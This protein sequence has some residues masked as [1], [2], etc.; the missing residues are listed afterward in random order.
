MFQKLTR[1]GFLQQVGL[2]GTGLILASCV[3]PTAQQAASSGGA[4]A[5]SKYKVTEIIVPSWWAPH[6][7][8]GAEASFNST[9]KDQTGL[10]VKYDFIGSD[11]NA[12]VFTNLASGTPY[13]VITFNADSVPEYLARGIVRPLDDLI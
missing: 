9:F 3:A 8:A 4:G 5:P 12:K 2:A 1:R 13:D 6:E 11:F 10:T 7:I